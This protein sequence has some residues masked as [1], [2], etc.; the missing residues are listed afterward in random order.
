MFHE[1]KS[2]FTP[3]DLKKILVLHPGNFQEG[4]EEANHTLK[5]RAPESESR[6][7]L[8]ERAG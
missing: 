5:V 7:F 8:K 3:E 4:I 6:S 1:E 2:S